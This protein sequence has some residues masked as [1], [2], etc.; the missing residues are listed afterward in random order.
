MRGDRSV[1]APVNVPFYIWSRWWM[2]QVR[3]IV[4]PDTLYAPAYD[5]LDMIS[6]AVSFV[7]DMIMMRTPASQTLGWVSAQLMN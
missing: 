1:I 7:C 5:E 6:D 3:A 2:F 4:P